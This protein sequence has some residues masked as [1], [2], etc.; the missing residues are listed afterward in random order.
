MIH[1]AAR[2]DVI[3]VWFKGALPALPAIVQASQIKSEKLVDWTGKDQQPSVRQ[4]GAV[5]ELPRLVPPPGAL[6]RLDLGEVD[7]GE[8]EAGG[9]A[10]MYISPAPFEE[11]GL[12]TNI[13]QK[14]IPEYTRNFLGSVPIILTLWPAFLIGLHWATEPPKNEDH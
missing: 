3:D 8:H 5:E 1:L 4:R 6:E 12:P 11:L 9:T 2:L 10:F 13:G 7:R 14:A